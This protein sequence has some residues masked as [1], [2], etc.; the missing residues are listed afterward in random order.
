M[1]ATEETLREMY[2]ARGMTW[3]Q[4]REE[5][6]YTGGAVHWW[7]QGYGIESRN[8]RPLSAEARPKLSAAKTGASRAPMSDV[9]ALLHAPIERMATIEGVV[10]RPSI[11]DGNVFNLYEPIHERRIECHFSSDKQEEVRAAWDRR[12]IVFGV[13]RFTVTG[14]PISLQVREIK[15]LRQQSELPQM[16]DLEGINITNG[17]NPTD[18]IRRSRDGW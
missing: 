17:A 11:H 10:E 13:A 5:L 2:H 18:Y 9:D 1:K 6:G 3:A 8:P 15:H 7:A 4:I 14:K 12:A 16:A